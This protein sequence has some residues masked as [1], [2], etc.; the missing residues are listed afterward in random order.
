MIKAVSYYDKEK[1][2]KTYKSTQIKS[3]V[4][5]GILA[6]FMAFVGVSNIFASLDDDSKMKTLT[7]ILGIIISVLSPYPLVLAIIN[8]KRGV[9]GAINDMGVENGSV[10]ITYL[11]K[12]RKFEVEVNKNDVIKAK[13]IMIK[14]VEKLRSNKTGVGIYLQNGDMYYIDKSDFVIG[15]QENLVKLFKTNHVIIKK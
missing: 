9:N 6:L 8:G 15:T 4:M 10:T 7:L 11:F 14:N 2:V 13:T 1:I 12:E 3:Y 5:S